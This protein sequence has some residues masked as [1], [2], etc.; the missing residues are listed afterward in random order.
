MRQQEV[1]AHGGV[2]GCSGGVGGAQRASP[3]SCEH[4]DPMNEMKCE[5]AAST[6]TTSAVPADMLETLTRSRRA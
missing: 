3:G 2:C 5:A 1:M 4:A 6:T